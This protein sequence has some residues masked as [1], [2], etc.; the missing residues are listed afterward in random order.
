MIVIIKTKYCRDCRRY[1]KHIV[2]IQEADKDKYY[3]STR[4]IC[5]SPYCNTKETIIMTLEQVKELLKGANRE[6]E[7]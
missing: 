2:V 6:E 5:L 4:W 3:F 7:E 1:E